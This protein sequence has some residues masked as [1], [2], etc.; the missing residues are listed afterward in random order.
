MSQLTALTEGSIG[1]LFTA[2][3]DLAGALR[4]AKGYN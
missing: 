2:G 4:Q 3:D 1:R